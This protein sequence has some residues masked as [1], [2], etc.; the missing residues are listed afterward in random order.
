MTVF[1]K[2]A[3]LRQT[4]NTG[5]AKAKRVALCARRECGSKRGRLHNNRAAGRADNLAVPRLGDRGTIRKLKVQ[6]VVLNSLCA[7]VFYLKRDAKAFVPGAVVVSVDGERI[8]GGVAIGGAH[9]TP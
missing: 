4:P 5:G 9:E 8:C 1:S 3:N 2:C 6:L 7:L